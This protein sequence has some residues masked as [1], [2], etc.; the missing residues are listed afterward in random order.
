MRLI[1]PN[2]EAQYEVPDEA[3]PL[4]GRDVQCSNC[5]Q[6]WFHAHPDAPA[7]P[8]KENREAELKAAKAAAPEPPAPAPQKVAA[9]PEQSPAA[10]AEPDEP[11][12]EDSDDGGAAPVATP[13][14]REL[15]PAVAD[16]LREEAELEKKARAKVTVSDVDSQPDLGSDAATPVDEARQRARDTHDSTT[17]I[18]G[19]SPSPPIAETTASVAQGN[20]QLPNVDELNS[21][22]RANTDRSPEGD[23]GQTAQI[24]TREKRSFGRGF[25]VMVLLVALLTL[26]YVFAPQIAQ[27]VP[28]VDPWLSSYVGLVDQGRSWLDGVVTD[29]LTWLDAAVASNDA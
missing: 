2:C 1:C 18:R 29:A 15:D 3:I 16:V 22:L 27:S 14:R 20:N 12:D 24:E 5:A 8:E 17:R 23:P 28:Q 25:S 26:V 9:K 13:K 10:E 6:I 7:A 19:E 4:E 11:V 21:T